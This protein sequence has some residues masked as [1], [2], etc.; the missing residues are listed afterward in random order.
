MGVTITNTSTQF[1]VNAKDVGISSK[2]RLKVVVEILTLLIIF[3]RL[4]MKALSQINVYICVHI[5]C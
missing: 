5:C 4:A 1:R 3:L 2:V